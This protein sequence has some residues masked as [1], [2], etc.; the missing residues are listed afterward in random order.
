M[1]NLNFI[2]PQNAN[3]LSCVNSLPPDGFQLKE[4]VIFKHWLLKNLQERFSF[5]SIT[6]VRKI[7]YEI[8]SINEIPIL[9]IKYL[10]IMT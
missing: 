3:I 4:D 6:Y 1:L 7:V 8:L 2:K 10:L 5:F 9:S